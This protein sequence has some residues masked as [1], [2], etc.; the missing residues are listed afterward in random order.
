M[1]NTESIANFYQQ[2]FGWV[3]KGL[4]LEHA[5]FNVFDI[6][7]LVDKEL[8][9]TPFKRRDFYKIT[10][11]YGKDVVLNYADKTVE[12]DGHAL[13]FSNPLIPYGWEGLEHVE[14][15]HY[16]IFNHCCPVN[17]QTAEKSIPKPFR[18]GL[19]AFFFKKQ[20]P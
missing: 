18:I 4:E 10:L 11:L 12:I 8:S 2:Q 1:K 6:S 20:A 19:R 15:G 16:C 5:H 3:P 14:T 9:A 7:S 17:F 13:V